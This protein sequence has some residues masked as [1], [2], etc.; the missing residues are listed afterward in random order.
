VRKPL[1]AHLPREDVLY[2]AAE[3]CPSCGGAHLVKLGEDITEVLEKI[4]ARLKVIR[5]VRPKFSCRACET[6]T[7]AP[8]PDLP[9]E[10]GRP[11]PGLLAHVVVSKYLDGLPL[12]RQSAIL[13]REGVEIERATLADWVGHTAWWLAP[14]ATMIG[15]HVRTAPV[16]HT[17]DTPVSLLSPGLGRARTG[18][19]WSIWRMNEVGRGRTPRPPGIGSAPTGRGN[20]RAIIWRDSREPSRPMH[21]PAMAR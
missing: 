6:I 18:R 5:H 12:Y 13:T 14:L 21:T 2:P 9:I 4:P 15:A 10:K 11:S 19:L 16:I 7:Q 20:V 3:V 17:D 1:P 8:S